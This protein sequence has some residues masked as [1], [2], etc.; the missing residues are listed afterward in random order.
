MPEF[1]A[2]S[3]SNDRKADPSFVVLTILFE[4]LAFWIIK[5]RDK[6]S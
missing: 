5:R 2:I 4:L 6:R 1:S 3:A